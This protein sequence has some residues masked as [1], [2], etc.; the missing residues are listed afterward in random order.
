[1]LSLVNGKLINYSRCV[2]NLIR[3]ILSWSGFY[4]WA[5]GFYRY[6]F[7]HKPKSINLPKFD[8]ISLLNASGLSTLQSSFNTET[9]TESETTLQPLPFLVLKDLFQR[10]WTGK[11][12]TKQNS[13]T[14]LGKLTHKLYPLS[15]L[16]WKY[17]VDSSFL[18]WTELI[19]CIS[20]SKEA[21]VW[22][23]SSPY[24]HSF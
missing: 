20:L 3:I 5:P 23:K 18:K 11:N 24:C 8:K 1:M 12:K 21:F 2:F 9:F 10:D 4:R 13:R 17:V 15:T 16:K 6:G 7:S 19:F 14:R 22:I